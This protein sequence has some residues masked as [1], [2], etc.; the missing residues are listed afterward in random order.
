[1]FNSSS[2]STIPARTRRALDLR[3]SKHNDAY[4]VE[5]QRFFSELA[6]T[7]VS[8]ITAGIRNLVHS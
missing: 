6:K 1:M 5:S 2:A 3:G 8:T 7:E 4:E